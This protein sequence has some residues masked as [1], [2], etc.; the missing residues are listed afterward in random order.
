MPNRVDVSKKSDE[1]VVIVSALRTPFQR[2]KGGGFK[3]TLPEK[4]LQDALKAIIDHT[5]IDPKLVEDVCVG[6][7]LSPG[8]GA[9]LARMAAFAAGYSQDHAFLSLF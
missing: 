8:G 9:T 3:K 7:V 4:L 6:T 2:A 1:D 5:K